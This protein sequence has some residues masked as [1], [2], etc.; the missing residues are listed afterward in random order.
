MRYNLP[1]KAAYVQAVS[2]VP[3]TS[4]LFVT[5]DYQS[6]AL[7]LWNVSKE[8]PLESIKIK[9]KGVLTSWSLLL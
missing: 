5:G 1:S 3:D 8:E 9:T 2:W 6:G 7:R 4:G